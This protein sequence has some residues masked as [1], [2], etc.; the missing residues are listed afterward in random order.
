MVDDERGELGRPEKAIKERKQE[1]QKEVESLRDETNELA[2]SIE[3]NPKVVEA[4]RKLEERVEN[5]ED[6]VL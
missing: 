5:L 6:E 1:R 4:I 2:E 3:G